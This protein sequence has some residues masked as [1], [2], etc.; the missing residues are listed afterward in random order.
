MQCRVQDCG[1][2]G[3][4]LTVSSVT[5]LDISDDSAPHHLPLINCVIVIVIVLFSINLGADSK[6][7]CCLA[8]VIIPEN[9]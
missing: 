6:L 4:C 2:C 8:S 5:G 3:D 1:E 9:L 7:F